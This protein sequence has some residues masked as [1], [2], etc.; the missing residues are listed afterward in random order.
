MLGM[1]AYLFVIF[2][3]AV[4]FLP[5]PWAFTPVAAALLFFGAHRSRRQLWFPVALLAVSDVILT[6]YVYHYPFTWDH[7]VTWVWYGAIVLL[8]TRLHKNEKPLWI[9]ASAL[10]SSVSFFLLSNFAV[11]ACFDMY[12][13]DFGGLMTSYAMGIPFF[14]NDVIGTL[15]FSAIFFGVP[16]LVRLPETLRHKTAA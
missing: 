12:P 8:G 7:Y 6:K 15:M 16:A 5:H 14:R 2:A 4:R 1:L 9:G 3:F 13:K 11:W 10:A